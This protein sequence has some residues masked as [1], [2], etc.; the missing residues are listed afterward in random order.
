M[1]IPIQYAI[2]YP[3]RRYASGRRLDFTTLT[4]IDFEVPDT[5]TFRGLP[6]AFR[7]AK[8]GGSMPTVFNAA[9]ERAVAMFLGHRVGFLDIYNIIEGAMDHHQ[10]LDNPTVDEILS[11]E[12]ET[13]DWIESRWSI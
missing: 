5:G 13:Y 12:A 3:N 1:K 10:V 7:A 11:A 4:Q 8:E 9:N 2:Y 6:L